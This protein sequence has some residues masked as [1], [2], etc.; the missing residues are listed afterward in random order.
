MSKSEIKLFVVVDQ[1]GKGWTKR[2]GTKD[3][4]SVYEFEHNAKQFIARHPEKKLKV[5]P[6]VISWTL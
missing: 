6:C 4:P 5:V 2:H 3:A 1:K